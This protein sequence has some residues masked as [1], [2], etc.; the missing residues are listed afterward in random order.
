MDRMRLFMKKH[1]QQAATSVVQSRIAYHNRTRH[2][3]ATSR[4]RSRSRSHSPHEG[5]VRGSGSNMMIYTEKPIILPSGQEVRGRWV[6]AIDPKGDFGGPYSNY[7][8][9]LHNPSYISKMENIHSTRRAQ[10]GIP[11][12]S[13]SVS[14]KAAKKVRPRR[15]KASRRTRRRKHRG[16][17]K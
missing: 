13:G 5:N 8:N 1:G 14:R 17:A 9:L 12:R 16:R 2:A 11:S 6:K 3:K 10:M 4:S 15:A 7:M